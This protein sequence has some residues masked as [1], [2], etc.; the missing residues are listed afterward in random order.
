MRRQSRRAELEHHMVETGRR[1][2]RLRQV[3]GWSQA[4]CAQLCR[5]SRV[6]W[7]LWESG[8]R[9]LNPYVALPLCEQLGVTLEFLYRGDLGGCDPEIAAQLVGDRPDATPGDENQPDAGGRG[10]GSLNGV[11]RAGRAQA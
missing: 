3:H 10:L 1:L 2:A 6:A 7:S 8:Q 11:P 5:V 9:L 4:R